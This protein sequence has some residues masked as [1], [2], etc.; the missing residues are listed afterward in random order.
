MANNSCLKDR[1]DVER[2]Y[3]DRGWKEKEIAL[4]RLHWLNRR[5]VVDL[6]SY[7]KRYAPEEIQR[8]EDGQP[9][10]F[11][12]FRPNVPVVHKKGKTLIKEDLNSFRKYIS[13]IGRLHQRWPFLPKKFWIG[14][15]NRLAHRGNRKYFVF[16]DG[17]A[18]DPAVSL[19]PKRLREK[20][21]RIKN[22]IER[23]RGET[24]RSIFN[25]ARFVIPVYDWYRMSDIERAFKR[26]Q[27]KKRKEQKLFEKSKK[28]YPGLLFAP[29]VMEETFPYGPK[30]I[31][32]T[33]VLELGILAAEY[34]CWETSQKDALIKICRDHGKDRK[35]DSFFNKE[36]AD[37]LEYKQEM[38]EEGISPHGQRKILREKFAS[39]CPTRVRSTLDNFKFRKITALKAAEALGPHHS[40]KVSDL[41]MLFFV[42]S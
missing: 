11:F 37:Y 22:T 1:I 35:G 4:I 33:E 8:W 26:V 30:S 39:G 15:Y 14:S 17:Y 40:N 21:S 24:G 29:N 19:H 7:L 6:R 34:N 27:E 3:L 25:G 5:F 28:K 10:Y 31:N 13:R 16:G 9:T 41:E 36:I 23:V 20:S 32:I 12:D 2:I 38:M 18:E 42:S